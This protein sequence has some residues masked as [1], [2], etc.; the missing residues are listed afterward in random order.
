MRM[1]ILQCVVSIVAAFALVRWSATDPVNP[2]VPFFVIL[3]V[4]FGAAWL[5]TF[6]YVWAR[7]GWKAARS[8]RLD[9]DA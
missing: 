9:G 2:K 6:L 3:V 5:A 8:M 4:G 7:F 1:M